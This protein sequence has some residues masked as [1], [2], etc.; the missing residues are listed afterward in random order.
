MR[1]RARHLDLLANPSSFATFRAR[2]RIIA[3][4]RAFLS[5]RDFMEV[6]TPI[7]SS[8]A[9]GA[10]ARPFKTA[11]AASPSTELLLRIAPELYLKRL[12]IGGFDR[13]FELGKQFRDEGLDSTH[14][15]EFTSCEFYA[16]YTGLD[17]VAQMVEQLWSEL[18]DCVPECRLPRV[19]Q[20]MNIFDELRLRTGINLCPNETLPE[21][22]QSAEIVKLA[23][24]PE[25][26]PASRV[27]DRLVGRFVEP[28][29]THPTLLFG[30]PLFTSPLAQASP[31]SPALAARFE[32]F[33]A[34][35]EVANAYAELNDP[36]AQ[37]SRFR[38]QA[39]MKAAGD[40]EIPA[41]DEEFLGA[42]DAGMPPTTGCGLGIDRLVMLLTSSASI[43]DVIFYPSTW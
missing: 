38:E 27:F 7:L 31:Q 6:E 2:S 17:E 14:N 23:Q 26:A 16:A 10:T 41:A 4:I 28:L 34:G 29:C 22:L 12:I 36:R 1:C 15:P 3:Q 20:K 25:N 42:L 13:V 21:Q 8:L 32:L 35:K 19:F 11:P 43:R 18:L 5:A 33:V 37:L 24:L 30:H 40:E 39:R 9:G